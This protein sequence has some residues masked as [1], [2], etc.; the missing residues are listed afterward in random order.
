MTSGPAGRIYD[1]NVCSDLISRITDAVLC[2][3]QEWQSRPLDRVWPVIFLDAIVCNVR[4][5]GTAK[6]KAA[7]L[8][9]GV[10][11]DGKK[12]VLGPG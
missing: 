9:V 7:H 12:E 6:S 10:G 1:I 3:A 11:V 2:E 8:A 4:D 5:S